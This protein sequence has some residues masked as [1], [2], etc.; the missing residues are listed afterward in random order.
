MHMPDLSEYKYSNRFPLPGVLA[1]GWLSLTHP[2]QHGIVPVSLVEKLQVLAVTRS[3]NQMRGFHIC[4]FCASPE[5]P[6]SMN[7]VERFLGSAEIWI[8]GSNVLLAAP[9]MIVHY[10]RDHEYR[11][12]EL[13]LQAL[14]A[15]DLSKW[16]PSK[17]IGLDLRRRLLADSGST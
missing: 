7:G 15:V 12:P 2:F 6:I 3:V 5:L 8:P 14:E 11:P 13:Y 17:D 4:E 1:V 10:V 9:D 16:H